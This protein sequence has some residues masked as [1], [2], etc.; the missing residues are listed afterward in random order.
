MAWRSTAGGIGVRRKFRRKTAK[1]GGRQ[2]RHALMIRHSPLLIWLCVVTGAGAQTRHEVE[3]P[4]PAE[5]REMLA[6]LTDY[7]EHPLQ[8]VCT[9]Q[10]M[11][12]NGAEAV[13]ASPQ[14]RSTVEVNL[15]PPRPVRGGI[16][17]SFAVEPLMRELLTPG[18]QFSTGWALVDR[19]RVAVYRY[20]R[21]SDG[22]AQWASI[23]ADRESGAISK[24]IFEGFNRPEHAPIFCQTELPGR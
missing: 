7:V 20:R 22:G 12:V 19:K 13:Q 24:I 14:L 8:L 11:N 2:G 1:L 4:T 5:Q 15:G 18:V 6:H 3:P 10:T 21:Q 17:T 23:Y 9:R 16:A